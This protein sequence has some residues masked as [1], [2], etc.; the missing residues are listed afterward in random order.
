MQLE[1][2]KTVYGMVPEEGL[3]RAG[4][5]GVVHGAELGVLPCF[6]L[7]LCCLPS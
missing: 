3:G 6:A 7:Q 4:E 5:G 2:C 1:G